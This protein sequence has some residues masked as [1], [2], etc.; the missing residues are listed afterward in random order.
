MHLGMLSASL[1]HC[2]WVT[3]CH[4]WHTN[5]RWLVTIHLPLLKGF[6]FGDWPGHDRALI[7][8]SSIRTLIDLAVWHGALSCWEKTSQQSSFQSRRE[9]AFSQDILI[10]V[11][12]TKTWE[13]Q[14]IPES[15]ILQHI[16]LWLVGL[17]RSLSNHYTR[18]WAKLKI[19]LIREVDLTAVLYEPILMVFCKPQPGSSLPLIDKELFSSFARPVLAIWTIFQQSS[20]CTSLHCHSF[21]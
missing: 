7:W 13:N 11:S 15:L 12:F 3:L 10:H 19:G 9:P 14:K 18:C 1:S 6:R 2:C 17:S 4:S 8:W 20:P 5:S 16:A 21:L